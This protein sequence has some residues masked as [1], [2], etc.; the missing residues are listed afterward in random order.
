MIDELLLMSE[1]VFIKSQNLMHRKG[2]VPAIKQG[3]VSDILNKG[4]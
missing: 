4:S 2:T 3:T 1:R